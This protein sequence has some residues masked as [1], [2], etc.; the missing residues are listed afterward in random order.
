MER[1]E[2]ITPLP[3]PSGACFSL[4]KAFEKKHQRWVLLL[5]HTCSGLE[6]V[7]QLLKTALHL[8]RTQSFAQLPPFLASDFVLT[9]VWE[10][11]G[12][13]PF[14]S[15]GMTW[16]PRKTGYQSKKVKWR[17]GNVKVVEVVSEFHSVPLLLKTYKHLTV[18]GVNLR[19]NEAF[20]QA[21][22]TH[23]NICRIVDLCLYDSKNGGLKLSVAF[24]KL[25]GDLETDIT[26]RA[27]SGSRYG[28]WKL[29]NLLEQAATGLAH[30]KS[31]VS[32]TKKIAHR[33]IKPS[34][35]LTD[36]TQLK[37][38]D[39]QSNE[40]RNADITESQVEHQ[41]PE[42]R[43]SMLSV[44]R[45]YDPFKADVYSLG[46]TF[47]RLASLQLSPTRPEQV[48][49]EVNDLPYSRSFKDILLAMLREQPHQRPTLEVM[50]PIVKKEVQANHRVQPND[51]APSRP[52]S[53]SFVHLEE[54][55]I[56]VFD[57]ATKVWTTTPLARP[58]Q[59][60]ES[61]RCVWVEMGLFCCGGRE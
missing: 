40:V 50:L 53:R 39:F 42:A 21:Q 54:Q 49:A 31:Q 20:L 34:N 15:W 25:E 2:Q 19:L 52:E 26:Q 48:H 61:S 44:W 5:V 32:S 13:N 18:E 45:N 41:S 22:L 10:F 46:L 43:S 11:P 35:I 30:A 47:L 37:V 36:G 16:P 38:F 8:Q 28:E 55:Q 56:K 27:V 24:E 4:S 17:L 7:N 33:D 12:P 23:S 58:I 29:W 51:E 6:E 57:F 59:V 14:P 3:H 60:D 9:C 1:F